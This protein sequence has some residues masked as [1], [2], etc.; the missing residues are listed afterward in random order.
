LFTITDSTGRGSGAAMGDADQPTI[1]G[2]LDIAAFTARHTD[3]DR[4]EERAQ[5]ARQ[6]LVGRAAATVRHRAL[7]TLSVRQRDIVIGARFR[8]DLLLDA[9]QAVEDPPVLT[10][11]QPPVATTA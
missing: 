7:A 10:P 2:E 11:I 3:P 1:R 4:V 8:E 6:V 5:I 9:A